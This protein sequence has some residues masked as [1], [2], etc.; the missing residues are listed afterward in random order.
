MFPKHIRGTHSDGKYRGHALCGSGGRPFPCPDISCESMTPIPKKKQ[1]GNRR[2]NETKDRN[3]VL[4][5]GVAPLCVKK[6]RAPV[7][8]R[9]LDQSPAESNAAL[10]PPLGPRETPMTLSCTLLTLPPPLLASGPIAIGA[11]L[12]PPKGSLTSPS[13]WSQEKAILC[14]APA[15]I[16]RWLLLTVFAFERS[17][18]ILPS[19][20]RMWRLIAT[21]PLLPCANA[22]ALRPWTPLLD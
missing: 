6:D 7:R 22:T 18:L 14:F 1:E 17:F 9:P 8:S 16:T 21:A 19:F 20:R 3:V 4:G 2:R 13:T 11:P 10:T 5:K 15:A 12:V